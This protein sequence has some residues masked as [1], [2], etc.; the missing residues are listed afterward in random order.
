VDRDHLAGQDV[1]NH[2]G[3]M[4]AVA[5][6]LGAGRLDRAAARPAATCVRSAAGVSFCAM[7]NRFGVVLHPDSVRWA[8]PEGVSEDVIAAVLLLHERSV[9]EIAPQISATNRSNEGI[10]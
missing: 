7:S 5:D 3:R 9:D 1:E 10:Q 8:A 2:I 6:G 4:H